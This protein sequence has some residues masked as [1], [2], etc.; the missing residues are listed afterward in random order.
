MA[1][2]CSDFV[3]VNACRVQG[4]VAFRKELVILAVEEI[5]G[6]GRVNSGGLNSNKVI[7]DVD[8]SIT[9]TLSPFGGTKGSDKLGAGAGLISRIINGFSLLVNDLVVGGDCNEPIPSSLGGVKGT[10][11]KD[12]NGVSLHTMTVCFSAKLV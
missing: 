11:Y 12:M 7:V 6:V 8:V 2:V 1:R 9:L 10:I 5:G 3:E 4:S